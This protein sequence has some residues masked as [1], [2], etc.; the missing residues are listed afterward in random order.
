MLEKKGKQSYKQS[1]L[2]IHDIYM[3]NDSY[4]KLAERFLYNQGCK[5][6]AR[7][8]THTHTHTHRDKTRRKVTKSRPVLLGRDSEA[9]EDYMGVHWPWRVSS[10]GHRQGFLWF[11]SHAGKTSPLSWLENCHNARGCQTS[12]NCLIKHPSSSQADRPAPFVSYYIPAL[13]IRPPPRGR[14]PGPQ[15]HTLVGF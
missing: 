11:R 2:Y 9:M 1:K 6:Y 3:Q 13:D 15:L 14:R 12:P 10:L 5:N 8:H 4:W 7:T